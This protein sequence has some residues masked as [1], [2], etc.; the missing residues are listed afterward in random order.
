MPRP[1]SR[2]AV[3]LTILLL[4]IGSQIVQ[5]LLVRES[6]VVFYGNEVSL[7]AFFGSWLF[8]VALGSWGVT[9]ARARGRLPDATRALAWLLLL[10]PLLLVLQVAAIRS[11]RLLFDIPSIELVPLGDLFL[12]LLAITLP[13]SLALGVA[14]PLSCKAL[15]DLG[16]AGEA[17]DGAVRG[18]SWLYV[19]EAL[20]A[21]LGGVLFT[22]LLVQWLGVWHGLGALTLALALTAYLLVPNW[23]TGAPAAV[24]GLAGLLF[25]VTPLADRVQSHLER[26]RFDSLQPGLEF[27]DAV[28][29]RYGHVALGRV[30]SQISV[31][32]D[33][34]VA[35]SFPQPS[36]LEQTAAYAYSQAA[37]AKRVLMFGG[38][39]DGLAAEL[40][41]YPLDQVDVV[42]QDPLAFERIRRF[43]TPETRQAL[44][45]P[46]LA[47]YFRDGRRYLNA[48]ETGPFDLV[49][50]LH[51][52]PTSAHSNRYFT[53]EFYSRV[54]RHL[55]PEGVFC[56]QVSSASNYLGSTV[57][58]YTGSV[59]RTLKEG[60]P[61][62]AILPGD[63]HLYCASAAPG[64]VTEDPY[65]LEERYLS[66]DVEHRFASLSF[67]SL[68][69]AE[70]IRYVR[71]QL[72]GEEGDLN[73]DSRPVTYYLNMMLWGRFTASGFVEWLEGLRR[74]GVWPYL[75]PVVVFLA[76]WLLRV[77]LQGFLRP[78]LRRQAAT[79]GLAV[80]GMVAMAQQLVI[81]FSYQAHV[82]FVFERVALLNGLFMTGLALGTGG[83]GQ[84]L[85]RRS[86]P[87]ATLATLMG[88][89]ALLLL[90]FPFLLE[91]MGSRPILVQ[92][93]AYLGLSV[94]FGFLTG[95]G[96]PLG[97]AQVH[98]DLGEVTATGGIS[99]AADSL[100]GAVGGLIT[101]ALL[102]PLLGINGTSQLLAIVSLSAALPLLYA[103]FAPTYLPR[104]LPRGQRAFP[105]LRVGWVLAFLVLTLFG[106]DLAQRG[107]EP[108][109]LLQFDEQRLAQASGSDR[110]RLVETPFPH[111]LGW[112]RQGS[113][114]AD[115][116]SASLSTMAVAADVR[117]YA[118][119]LNL[120]VSVGRNGSLRGARYLDSNETPA[121]IAGIQVWLDTLSGADLSR[122]GLDLQRVDALSGAT[123]S[124]QAAL[125]AIN[126]SVRRAGEAAFNQDW[127]ATGPEA[128]AASGVTSL[129]FLLTLALLLIF[130]PIYL[131]GREGARLGLQWAVLLIL[132]FWL[133][134]LVTEVDVVNLSQGY[135]SS[136][137]DNPQRWLLIGFVVVS[138]I[139]FGQ[140][141][142]GYLCPFGALQEF[143]SRLGRRLGLR[144]YPQRPLETRARFMKH[145]LLCLML[146]AVWVTDDAFWASFNPMQHAFGGR[147]DG[148][149]GPLIGVA[150][151][152]ALFYFRFWCRYLCPFGALLSLSNK[153]ALLQWLAPKRRFEHCDLGVREEFDMDC[154]RCNRCLT[155]K[156]TGIRH[157]PAT[158]HPGASAEDG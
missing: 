42:E 63:T 44:Q 17:S 40:L 148:W 91:S 149:L 109:P 90:G 94:L 152:G 157:S 20:G 130:F 35:E 104:L 26:L 64:R 48:L 49:L 135:W 24:L 54:R 153:L 77:S 143:V 31:V 114:Q 123:L 117:G 129:R 80:L 132:G 125:R 61:Y 106:W 30:G 131:S 57:R 22:F 9:R 62:I 60:F 111:Y 118:G 140:V 68:L 8:W 76:L 28:E 38:L 82:G 2:A 5:A 21:L 155:G 126:R 37:G 43:L 83:L 32:R 66:T 112:D 34:H 81:L 119:P 50:A 96:F 139:L 41:R 23:H 19:A 116:D 87:D 70:Q 71:D 88:V 29:T 127:A 27:L 75:V 122:A 120:L 144:S 67:L 4:G 55:A 73:A 12:A 16:G 33:G 108:G 136:W 85:A 102:V 58:S 53:R 158:M 95:V 78:R 137:R 113:A 115:P 45:D 138:G 46:R 150:L 124:S 142:C 14:F 72:E 18:V 84:H 86:N 69:P 145:L 141:W 3:F 101:G 51:A 147:W 11:V 36:A 156:D 15:Q 105:W 59:Y 100:G 98:R 93:A 79:Y 97:V 56:T 1:P 7:G 151:V 25:A 10:L 146:A 92:E 6:L 52:V 89:V 47:V 134:S 65:E 154:I 13:T 110:F 121:Y 128:P 103:R 74:M 107:A 39:S 133:N 99:E